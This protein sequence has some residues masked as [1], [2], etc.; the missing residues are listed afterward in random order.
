[1]AQ[2]K[3]IASNLDSL[4]EGSIVSDDDLA[5]LNIAALLDGGHLATVA[6]KF[7]KIDDS[8]DK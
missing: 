5:G 2:Y 4:A 7:T 1:M 3:V 8:K 6:A